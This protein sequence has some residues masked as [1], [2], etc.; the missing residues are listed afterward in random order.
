MGEYASYVFIQIIEEGILSIIG[1]KT[2]TLWHISRENVFQ[3]KYILPE[4]ILQVK[5]KYDWL[6]DFKK[7]VLNIYWKDWCWRTYFGYLKQRTDSLEKTDGGKV[8]GRKRT[9]CQKMRWLDGITNSI[10]M[11]LSKL[12]E[13]VMDR[14]AWQAAVHGVTK[15]RTRL[16]DWT[17]LMVGW[18]QQQ[19]PF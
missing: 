17:E 13:L 18:N 4:H 6:T 3:V 1:V 19:I 5:Y 2:I 10:D 9:G 8:E 16:S 12:W 7:S 15:S 11:N 14:E